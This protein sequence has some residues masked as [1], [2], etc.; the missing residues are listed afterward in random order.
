MGN[1]VA[2]APGK[3]KGDQ[4]DEAYLQELAADD[5][6]NIRMQNDS[7]NEQIEKAEAHLNER[8]RGLDAVYEDQRGKLESGR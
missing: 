7:L 6:F 5:W 8:K 1:K 3:G 2:S 4:L